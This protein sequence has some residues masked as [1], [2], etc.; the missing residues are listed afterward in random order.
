MLFDLPAKE[1]PKSGIA[2]K[3]IDGPEEAEPGAARASPTLAARDHAGQLRRAPGAAAG[4]RPGHRGD[5]RAHGLEARPLPQGRAA[6]RRRTRSSPPTPRACRSPSCPRASTPTCRQRFCGVH[7]FNPPRYMHLVE[8]I[9]TGADRSGGAGPARDLPH[10]HARQGRGARQGHAELHRQPHRHLQHPGHHSSEAENFGLGFDVVD[11]LTGDK[12]GRAEV[13]HLPHRRRGRPR[14][15][16]ARHPDD[17]GQPAD[18]PFAPVYETP[19]VLA[20]ADRQGRARPEDR[21]RLLP[22]GRQGHPAPRPGQGATTCRRPAR[23]TR[24]WRGS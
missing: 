18:D 7:F 19:A 4:L 3:A 21:R 20:G 17:A 11:D 13:R 24:P 12:L 1:G 16:G 10:H 23:P 22:Q 2:I 8:L 9:P 14:H 6:H 15:D 5:R